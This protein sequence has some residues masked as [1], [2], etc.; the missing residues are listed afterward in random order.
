[1][2]T[3]PPAKSEVSAHPS[4]MAVTSAVDRKDQQADV[5]RKLKLYGI[6]QAFMDGRMPDNNQIDEALQYAI[7]H[8]PVSLEKLSPDGKLLVEDVRDILE[9]ARLMVAEKNAGELF[10]N[11]I[12]STTNGDITRG[13]KS[14]DEILPVSKDEAAADAKQGATHLRVLLTLFL[15][16]SEARKLLNDMGLVAR[17]LFATGAAKAADA[18]RPDQEALDQVDKSAPSGEWVSA[19]GRKVGRDETPELEV[20]GP[21]KLNFRMNPKDDPA[22]AQVTDHQGN[23][24]TAGETAEIAKQKYNEAQQQ[25]EQLKQQAADTA[26]SHANDV[27]NSSDPAAAAR[28]KADQ[29]QGQAQNAQNNFDQEGAKQD[30]RNAKDKVLNKIPDEHREKLE[31]A[32]D[33]TKEFFHDNF[34]KERR[35]QFIYRLKKVVVECQEHKD[36][37]EAMSFFLDKAEQYRGHAEHLTEHGTDSA[38]KVAEDPHYQNATLQFR[39]LLE[40]FANGQSTQPMMDAVN[41]LYTD[42]D[43]DAELK[44]WWRHVNEFIH[45]S[46]LEP[47]WILDDECNREAEELQEKGKQFF[48]HKYKGHFD[49]FGNSVQRFF[50]A[51]GDDPLNVR[52]GEDWKRLVKDLLFNAE[53]NLTFKPRLWNDIRRVILPTVIEQI[54]YVPIPRAEYSDKNIDLVIE[55][56]VLQ[57]S[58]IFPNIIDLHSEHTFKFSPYNNL[59]DYNHHVFSLGFSQI[60]ADLRDVQFAFRRKTGWPKIRDSG[61]ADCFIGGS[62]ITVNVTLES[63]ENRRDSVFKVKDI[64]VDIGTLKFAIRDSKHD[65]LYKFVKATANNLIKKAI[66]VAIKEA[67]RNAFEY[68]DE[69]LVEV[70]NR[71]DDAKKS[72]EIT[73]SQALKDIFARKKEHAKENK[74]KADESTGTFKIVTDREDSVVKDLNERQSKDSW[75]KRAFRTEDAAHAGKEWRSPVFSL[76]SK[77]HPAHTGEHHPAVKGAAN[78]ATNVTGPR[79]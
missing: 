36:Y 13:A 28:A 9:S 61:L 35:D 7:G 20:S 15:T 17:D 50:V 8:S 52:F 43:N 71:L 21:G 3:L 25:K 16:N 37:Q 18:V 64:H 47:G 73:R 1:M 49:N 58:N 14:K 33:E 38:A 30:A 59:G 44:A 76:F 45:K 41:Q 31:H 2:S 78:T 69:Q 40:R 79:I 26:K 23:T 39:A 4:A 51:M 10:Q 72:D 67:I 54:G 11:F 53:G 34:P 65:L 27:A 46:L 63:V 48:E 29:A 5:E 60:Q 56:L 57:G 12:W 24:R 77:Q 62:G 55:N 66:T 6:I 32:V 22:N 19:D 42:A 75:A 68:V 70:R 74:Q